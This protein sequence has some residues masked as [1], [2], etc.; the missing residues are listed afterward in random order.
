MGVEEKMLRI[1]N[2]VVLDNISEGILCC[3]YA[4]SILGLSTFPKNLITYFK[5]IHKDVSTQYFYVYRQ[6][7]LDYRYTIKIRDGLY[8]TNYER[9]ICD[10]ISNECEYK[11]IEQ[12]IEVY[13]LEFESFDELFKV[14]EEYKVLD[15]LKTIIEEMEY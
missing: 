2:K 1:P 4:S 13:G 6:D 9:T 8:I 12:S 3:E 7:P 15:K 5:D 10:L 11:L 14:A